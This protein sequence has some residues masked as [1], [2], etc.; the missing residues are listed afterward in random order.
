MIDNEVRRLERLIRAQGYC[1]AGPLFNTLC[2]H[3]S[4]EDLVAA[5]K[6]I[7]TRLRFLAMTESRSWRTKDGRLIPI[8]KLGD[9]HLINI[10]SYI[11][12]RDQDNNR[13]NISQMERNILIE[14]ARKRK[15][16][17]PEEEL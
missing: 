15:L 3:L 7:K 16:V 5:E 8:T 12:R 17:L 4:S 9:D 11:R 2:S 6:L 14:E 13:M 1:N 10:I